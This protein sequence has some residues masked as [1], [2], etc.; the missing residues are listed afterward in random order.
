M[1]S[2]IEVTIWVLSNFPLP[3]SCLFSWCS[4]FFIFDTHRLKTGL[5][6]PNLP[7]QVLPNMTRCARHFWFLP[8]ASPLC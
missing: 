7:V 4:V 6:N 8:F 3:S 2:R 5:A 1:S